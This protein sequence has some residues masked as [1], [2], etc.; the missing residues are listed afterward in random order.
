MLEAPIH[1][2]VP[3]LADN[4]CNFLALSVA[5]LTA[6][7]V[8]GLAKKLGQSSFT[9]ITRFWPIADGCDTLAIVAILGIPHSAYWTWSWLLEPRMVRAAIM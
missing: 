3:F 9:V 4:N 5:I 2:A 8:P 6:I 7:D 1:V